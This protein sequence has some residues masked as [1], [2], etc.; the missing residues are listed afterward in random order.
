MPRFALTALLTQRTQGQTSGLYVSSSH[1]QLIQSQSVIFSMFCCS[2][3]SLNQPTVYERQPVQVRYRIRSCS[4]PSLPLTT[5][6]TLQ[7]PCYQCCVHKLTHS[8]NSHRPKPDER[9][10]I[11]RK[12]MIEMMRVMI[13]QSTNSSN[14][15]NRPPSTRR[16]SM[17]GVMTTNIPRCCW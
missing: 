12:M 14:T 1:N 2:P 7:H 5:F 10:I 17:S 15:I 11:W 16:S 9:R 8:L 4:T 3:K 13:T 6:F